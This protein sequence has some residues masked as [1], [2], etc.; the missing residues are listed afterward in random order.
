[1]ENLGLEQT[2]AEKLNRLADNLLQADLDVQ[3]EIDLLNEDAKKLEDSA[4][5]VT[6]TIGDTTFKNIDFKYFDITIGE[7]VKTHLER[8]EEE[9]IT[10]Y[11][12][13][14]YDGFNGCPYCQIQEELKVTQAEM[15]SVDNYLREELEVK[16]LKD[17][18]IPFEVVATLVLMQDES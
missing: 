10:N 7:F 1:M 18:F 6:V 3:R 17:L 9:R 8:K 13:S 4:P 12:K 15:N 5:K 11:L 14:K 16:V 2:P